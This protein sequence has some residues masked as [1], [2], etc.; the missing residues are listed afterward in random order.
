[1]WTLSNIAIC[2]RTDGEFRLIADLGPDS[3]G[4]VSVGAV[5]DRTFFEA[6]HCALIE[7]TYT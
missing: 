6:K 2:D 1:M 5:Y 3:T 7:R 4:M